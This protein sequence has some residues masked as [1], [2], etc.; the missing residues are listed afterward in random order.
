VTASPKTLRY[1]NRLTLT[2]LRLRGGRVV[3]G[4]H[5]LE[6]PAHVV[7]VH[8]ECLLPEEP[9]IRAWQALREAWGPGARHLPP[10]GRLRLTLRAAAS[11]V[12]LLVEGG[13][14]DWD[15]SA[16][17]SLAAFTAVWHRPEGEARAR[18]VAGESVEDVWGGE[19]LPVEGAAFLQVNREAA[20]LLRHHVLDIVGAG[21]GRAVDGY[22]GVGVYGRELA[23]QGWVVTGIELDPDACDA[24]RRQAPAGLEIVEGRVE[25]HLA[26]ALPADLVLLNPPRTGIHASIPRLLVER[27]VERVVYVSCDPATLARDAARLEEAYELRAIR[28]FDLFPQTPHVETVA[29]FESRGS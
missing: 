29:R 18:R 26:D 16:V 24:A 8:G 1:R 2:L 22:C 20:A 10:G 28:S 11:G 17:A 5:A 9:I 7:D 13:S 23:R 15:A 27:P 6:E 4:F 12:S 25:L 14:P 19:A 3:A 21:T